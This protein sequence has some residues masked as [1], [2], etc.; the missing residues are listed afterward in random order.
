MSGSNYSVPI[1]STEPDSMVQ[2]SVHALPDPVEPEAERTRM[3]RLKMLLV[4]LICA[5]PVVASYLTYYVIRPQ[6]RVNY[7][8]L[9]QPIVPIPSDGS[10]TL[11]GLHGEAVKPSS[12]KGQWLL[13]VV[14]DGACDAEC[15]RHLYEQRQLREMLGKDKDRL[16]RV[17]FVTG[18][19]PVRSE[20]MPALSQAW[21]LKVSPESLERWLKP[22]PGHRL[23]DHLYLVDPRGD[24][25]MRFP[26][27]DDPNLIKKDL[28]RLM[29]ANESWDEA[30]R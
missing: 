22:E 25:M 28:T 20:L 8:T 1:E 19:E 23:A 26:A 30:G 10:W 14:A 29:K 18:T 27:K 11:T 15:E 5:A 17:W 7:G 9:I 4:W 3:G 13:V 21:V 6:G 2:L 12:L 24:W 16:D